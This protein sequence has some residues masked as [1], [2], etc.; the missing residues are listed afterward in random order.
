MTKG[1]LFQESKVISIYKNES[2]KY[3]QKKKPPT[4]ISTEAKKKKTKKNP[5]AF[6]RNIFRDKNTKPTRGRKEFPPTSK[7]HL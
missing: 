1:D 4:I 3:T 6:N 2:M 5:K 7:G